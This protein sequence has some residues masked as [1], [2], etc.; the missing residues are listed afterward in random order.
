M[1]EL[2]GLSISEV[3]CAP[4]VAGVRKVWLIDCTRVTIVVTQGLL[5]D[6]VSDYTVTNLDDLVAMDF[7]KNKTAFFNQTQ[8][9][10]NSA[11]DYSLQFSYEALTPEIIYVLNT[12][13]ATCCF[14]AFIQLNSGIILCCGFDYDHDTEEITAIDTPLQFKGTI[15]SGLGNNDST[16]TIFEY[17]G[18]G[19][20]FALST[21]LVAA[22][23][24]DTTGHD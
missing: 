8:A 4:K 3:K 2:I 12:N 19:K 11:V 24:D 14:V 9:S 5:K 10:A 18:Q 16:T 23:F 7:S 22:D 20:S 13:R 21:S 1:P 15:N 17:V 6:E